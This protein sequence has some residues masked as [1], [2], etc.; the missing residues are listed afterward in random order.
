M[1]VAFYLIKKQK[2]KNWLLGFFAII[3]YLIHISVMWYDFIK[4][5]SASAP[6]TILV[7]E[8]FCNIIMYGLIIVA[9]IKKEGLFF[10][11]IAP[12]IAWGGIFGA[13]IAI[14][15]NN[16]LANGFDFATNWGG[17]KSMISHSTLMAGCL[18]LF[19]GGYVKV[20]INNLLSWLAGLVFCLVLTLL[21]NSIKINGSIHNFDGMSLWT[22]FLKGTVFY[23]YVLMPAL[24]GIIAV[25]TLIYEFVFLKKEKRFYVDFGL[26]EYFPKKTTLHAEQVNAT[27]IKQES[28]KMP[29][30]E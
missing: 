4:T 9:F 29:E 30:I 10:K 17:M 5:G 16:F 26:L 27:E 6:A 11:W 20:R 13:L 24:T 12:F 14:F 8:Y 25:I 15:G 19:V 18:W 28:E 1:A 22:P 21:L 3:T 23:G 7:P 2:S